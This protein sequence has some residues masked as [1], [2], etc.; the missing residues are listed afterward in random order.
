MLALRTALIA[1]QISIHSDM[2]VHGS[3]PNRSP[4]RRCGLTLRYCAADV[5]AGMPLG[6]TLANDDVAGNH[7]FAAI[8]LH[9]TALAVA[10]AAVFDATLSFFVSHGSWALEC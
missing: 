5:R 4:R 8:F 1:G 6:A 9:T 2:L 3:A 10:V 7:G